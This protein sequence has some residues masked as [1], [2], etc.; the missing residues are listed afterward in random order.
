MHLF[1][2]NNNK[3]DEW[4]FRGYTLV[5]TLIAVSLFSVVMLVV[6]GSFVSVMSG[7]EKARSQKLVFNNLNAALESMTRNISEGK[8]YHC[9]PSG[10]IATVQD[11]PGG[12]Y[13]LAYEA[14]GGDPTTTT[15]QHVYKFD[16]A[17]GRLL[18]SK[19]GGL[20]GTFI[21]VTSANIKLTN[22]QF[23]TSSGGTNEQKRVLI[24][25]SGVSGIKEEVKTSFNLQT[26]VSER[27]PVD[28]AI[29][30]TY[31]PGTSELIGN[32]DCNYGQSY[33][34]GSGDCPSSQV[35]NPPPD[36]LQCYYNSNPNS[37]ACQIEGS[38]TTTVD[39]KNN[40]RCEKGDGPDA[41]DPSTYDPKCKSA[42][43]QQEES[44]WGSRGTWNFPKD[45]T[46]VRGYIGPVPDIRWSF[47]FKS[48][49]CTANGSCCND[50]L[51]I[52]SYGQGIT[53]PYRDSGPSSTS[54]DGKITCHIKALSDINNSTSYVNTNVPWYGTINAIAS[55]GTSNDGNITFHRMLK[56]EIWTVYGL[57]CRT[58]TNG[59]YPEGCLDV[60]SSTNTTTTTTQIDCSSCVPGQ[61][62]CAVNG[63]V[64]PGV[65]TTGLICTSCPGPSCPLGCVAPIPETRTTTGTV[66]GQT[67][68]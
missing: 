62:Y 54:P 20:V 32:G 45:S 46:S 26:T 8:V 64:D 42:Q 24:T 12:S 49:V 5:E 67:E 11:C 14:E 52:N 38:T 36:N 34:D 60:E 66:S 68:F 58:A 37:S 7:N 50:Y 40:N 19:Q 4:S 33:T 53:P 44:G 63:C 57:D 43:P 55:Y 9:G 23:E 18:F 59:V 2:N 15:D 6:V 3:R 13:F 48:E 41:G 61:S 10:N 31:V 47:E 28:T 51:T 39:T 30:Y 16:S 65:S 22:A 35:V 17:S 21:A 1:H 56:R 29:A 25:L 27:L